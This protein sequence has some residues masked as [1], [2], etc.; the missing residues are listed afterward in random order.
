MIALVD[1]NNFFVS[2]ARLEHPHLAT[3]PVVVLSNNDG[4]IIS[5]SQEAKAMGIK[6]GAPAFTYRAL[7]ETKKVIAISPNFKKYKAISEH[8]YQVLHTIVPHVEP[9]SIDE[10]FLQ[11]QYNEN[12]TLL[13]EKIQHLVKTQTGIPVSVGFATTKTLAKLATELAKSLPKNCCDLT[14]YP[15]DRL[16]KTIPVDQIWGIGRRYSTLLNRYGIYT[17]HAFKYLDPDWVLKRMSIIGQKIQC[18]LANTVCFPMGQS[19]SHPNFYQMTY[20]NE[21][22]YTPKA[23]KSILHSRS[24]RDKTTDIT[25]IKHHLFENIDAATLK[26]RQSDLYANDVICFIKTSRFEANYDSQHIH[27]RFTQASQNTRLIK[28]IL[29]EALPRMVT[30]NHRY[31]KAGIILFNL[32]PS[33]AIQ[34]S[35]LTSPLEEKEHTLLHTLDSL[36]KKYPKGSEP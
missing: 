16:L 30:A 10:S 34:T 21:P 26:L 28:R 13:G 17:A 5:R 12:T 8:I 24:F 3:S 29:T 18:E 25:A 36:A 4:C 20:D 15:L 1:C 11:C 6:M 19:N 35:W 9:Y 31:A 22:E 14:Q 7:F 23:A 27:H 32:I 2:C 33:T